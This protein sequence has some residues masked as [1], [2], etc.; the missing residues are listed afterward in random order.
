MRI[1]NSE[2]KYI[3]SLSQKKTRLN[4][5]KFV[6]EGWRALKEVLNSSSKVELVAVLSRFLDDPDYGSILSK[7]LERNVSA[8]TRGSS[9]CFW[10]SATSSGLFA[11][12][13]SFEKIIQRE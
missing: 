3:R 12:T 5:R 6:L 13:C 1:S 2:L 8:A 10:K 11:S 4:E 7:L 9:G